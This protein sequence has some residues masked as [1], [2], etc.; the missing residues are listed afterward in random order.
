MGFC[1]GIRK[2]LLDH[3]KYEIID[4]R[5]WTVPEKLFKSLITIFNKCAENAILVNCFRKII[6]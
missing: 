5:L 3:T 6:H 4:F 1:F 2:H